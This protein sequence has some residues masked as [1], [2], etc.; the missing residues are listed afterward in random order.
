MPITKELKQRWLE[1]LKSGDAKWH[2]GHLK[3]PDGGSGMCCLGHLAHIQG[4]LSE[5]GAFVAPVDDESAEF[6]DE[7]CG[8]SIV[9]D[10]DEFNGPVT[11][12]L[13]YYGLSYDEQAGL[14]AANDEGGAF[15][16]ELIEALPET[17]EPSQ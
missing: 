17:E 10:Y 16:I 14:A 5:S 2:K 8:Y 13:S 15:P 1:R 11:D 9:V 6:D 12:F 4:H 3:D 7:L